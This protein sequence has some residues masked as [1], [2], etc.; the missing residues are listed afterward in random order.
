MAT[1][2]QRLRNVAKNVGRA[3]VT[4]AVETAEAAA[5]EALHKMLARVA[6]AP[7]HVVAQAGIVNGMHPDEINQRVLAAMD[8]NGL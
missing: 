6:S 1:A 7:P 3:A 5:V 2:K 8:A 4:A